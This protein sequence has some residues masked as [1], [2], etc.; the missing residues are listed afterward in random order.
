MD[1]AGKLKHANENDFVFLFREAFENSDETLYE[2]ALEL[3]PCF[4]EAQYQMLL[5][6]FELND[7][8]DVFHFNYKYAELVE[9]NQPIVEMFKI[10]FEN[11]KNQKVDSYVEKIFQI[12]VKNSR[13]IALYLKLIKTQYS[14]QLAFNDENQLIN[15]L[16]YG[17]VSAIKVSIPF[18]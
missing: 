13:K 17:K 15:L 8:I 1:D 10:I 5:R 14:Y 7:C 11:E 2:R 18:F 6:F 9:R 16:K 4:F 3:N 12:Q